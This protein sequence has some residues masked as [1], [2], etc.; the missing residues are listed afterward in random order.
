MRVT[1][2]AGDG[3]GRFRAR[4]HRH[5]RSAVAARLLLV[6]VLCP[7][8]TACADE[9]V[10]VTPTAVRGRYEGREFITTAEA[11]ALGLRGNDVAHQLSNHVVD[12]VASELKRRADTGAPA[13]VDLAAIR[14]TTAGMDNRGTVVYTVEV[15]LIAANESPAATHFDHRGGWGHEGGDV[16]AWRGRIRARYGVEPECSPKIRT[17]EGLVETWCQWADPPVEATKG[18][19]QIAAPAPPEPATEPPRP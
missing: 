16:D 4:A 3:W 17:P 19:E 18:P 6:A 7:F 13:R 11:A 8:S 12:A 2:G 5:I 10:E 15:P 14:M 1:I 9:R